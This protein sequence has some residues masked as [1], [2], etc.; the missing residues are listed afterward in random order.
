MGQDRVTLKDK[1]IMGIQDSLILIAGPI[2][3]SKGS[4]VAI[5][6]E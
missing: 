5:Y 3:G 2:P 4:V 1:E 6:Q